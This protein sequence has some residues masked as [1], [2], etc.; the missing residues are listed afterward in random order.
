MSLLTSTKR[1]FFILGAQYSYGDS[2]ANTLKSIISGNDQ[3]GLLQ[4]ALK[5]YRNWPDGRRIIRINAGMTVMNLWS[6]TS[7][8]PA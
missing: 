5:I 6:F 8:P 3:L 7:H 4:T 1:P 2:E